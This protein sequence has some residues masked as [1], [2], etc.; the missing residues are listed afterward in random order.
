M[1]HVPE[2]RSLS[3]EVQ[4]QSSPA[5][6]GLAT[7]AKAA[8]A[9]SGH[10]DIITKEKDETESATISI[11]GHKIFFLQFQLRSPTGAAAALT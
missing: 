6:Q 9:R 7:P 1:R 4:K 5:A 11:V 10:L 8:T 2:V 3:S